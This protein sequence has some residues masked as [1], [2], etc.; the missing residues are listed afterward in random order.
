MKTT[1][2]WEVMLC[3]LEE[4]LSEFTSQLANEFNTDSHFHIHQ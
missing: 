1:N 3:S 2:F 4:S